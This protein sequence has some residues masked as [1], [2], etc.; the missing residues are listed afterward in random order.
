MLCS[1]RLQE[2]PS[3]TVTEESIDL[4]QETVKASP[5]LNDAD[6]YRIVVASTRT[7]CP[8]RLFIKR[9]DL[10]HRLS[11]IVRGSACSTFED[12]AVH[13]KDERGRSCT[14][15]GACALCGTS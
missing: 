7:L 14:S 2:T 1:R 9:V 3:T 12:W 11:G 13:A 10:A 4:K 15:W 5:V 6:M 8:S